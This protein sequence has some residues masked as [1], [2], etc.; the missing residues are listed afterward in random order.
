MGRNH[1]FALFSVVANLTLGV[2]PILW[3][4][5]I[6][7]LRSLEVHWRAF[8]WNRFT[9]FFVLA[10][11]LMVVTFALCRRLEEPE[12]AK[13]SAIFREILIESPQ[14]VWLRIWPKE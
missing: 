14:R 11:V 9:V 8:E 6:D 12:A 7:A 1:F 5:L 4:V 3:G 10:E 2:A 13:M